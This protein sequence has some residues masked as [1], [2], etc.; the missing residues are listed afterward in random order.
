[1]FGLNEGKLASARISPGVGIQNHGRSRRGAARLHAGAQLALGDVLEVLIDGQLERRAGGRWPL[2]PAEGMPARIGLNQ[3]G[4]RLAADE[5]VVRAFDPAEPDVV[6]ADVAQ[7][8]RRQVAVRV[9]P[10]VLADEPNPFHLQFS[11]PE[12]LIG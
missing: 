7:D 8:V 11:H 2:D 3:D 4:A 5:R 6:D 9:A 10:L 1:M 12:C